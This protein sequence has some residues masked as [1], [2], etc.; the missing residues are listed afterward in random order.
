M[1]TTTVPDIPA[2]SEVPKVE[3]P[4]TNAEQK[5]SGEP[6]VPNGTALTASAATAPTTEPPTDIS[7]ASVNEVRPSSTAPSVSVILSAPKTTEELIAARALKRA[8]R[9]QA[10]REKAEGHKSAGDYLFGIKNYKACY[11]QYLEAIQLWGS[12]PA[13]FVS[14]ASAYRKLKWYEEAAHAATRALTLDPKNTEARY[15]RGVSRLEQRLLKPAKI[16]FETVLAQDPSHLLARAALTEVNAFMSASTQLG[17]HGLSPSPID[18][19]VKDIDFGFPPLDYDGMEVDELSDSSD[20]NHV[21]NGIQCRFYNHDGCARGSNCIFSHAPD[22]KSVRDELGKNSALPKRGWW[23]N[24]EQVA[25]VKAVLEAAEKQSREQRQLEN[26]RW[27]AHLKA[28]RAA[29]KSKPP[30]SAGVRKEKKDEEAQEEVKADGE[31]AA[32][33]NATDSAAEPPKSAGVPPKSAGLK[34]RNGP[35][36]RKPQNKNTKKSGDA[37]PASTTPKVEEA[38]ATKEAISSVVEPAAPGGFTDYQLN[39]VPNDVKPDPS[40]TLPY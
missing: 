21:G 33:T 10:I 3:N 40:A 39:A 35:P 12:N 19:V 37:A 27:K 25:K 26:E 1:S 16:D 34:K 17:S 11:A 31:V 23:T 5:T 2:V 36:H 20:C 15:V 9:R 8:A 18:D 30:K 29:S 13:Y 14:L 22:E 32:T 24:P 38:P 28:M 7:S 6:Q 4:T